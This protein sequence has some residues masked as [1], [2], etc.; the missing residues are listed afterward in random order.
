MSTIAR[1]REEVCCWNLLVERRS[2]FFRW[3]LKE[4]KGEL[5]VGGLVGVCCTEP[6]FLTIVAQVKCKR[7]SNRVEEKRLLVL[8]S[9]IEQWGKSKN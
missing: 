3:L 8:S 2:Y 6:A 5:L 9:D 1:S 4:G 7:R